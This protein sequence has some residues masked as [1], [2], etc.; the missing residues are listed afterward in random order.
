M[1]YVFKRVEPDIRVPIA[2]LLNILLAKPMPIEFRVH[3]HIDQIGVRWPIIDNALYLGV[4]LVCELVHLQPL[5]LCQGQ[6]AVVRTIELE[7]RLVAVIR[8]VIPEGRISCHKKLCAGRLFEDSPD[9]LGVCVCE[10]WFADCLANFIDG[11]VAII[12]AVIKH[13]K[14][15]ALTS[16]EVVLPKTINTLFLSVFPGGYQGYTGEHNVPDREGP[17]TQRRYHQLT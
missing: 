14:A 4:Q 11:L 17:R 8:I 10:S 13:P 15:A 3:V 2:W 6:N 12:V 7:T 16:I 9:S 1:A 5:F